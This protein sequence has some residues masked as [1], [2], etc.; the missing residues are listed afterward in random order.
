M[1]KGISIYFGFD[2]DIEERVKKIKKAG[3]DA[4]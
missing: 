1:N 2:S 3:F 4:L